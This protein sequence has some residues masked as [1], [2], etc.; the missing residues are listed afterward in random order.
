MP[1]IVETEV[2]TFDE[3]DDE[4]KDR[5]RDWYRDGALDY[6]W[7]EF[8]IEDFCHVAEILG[9]DIATHPVRLASGGTGQ[10][11]CVQF[12]GFHN[13]GDGASFSGFY[14]CAKNSI[15][16]IKLHAP[17]DTELHDIAKRLTV[18]QGRNFW[19][20]YAHITQRGRYCHENTMQV[21]V[22]RYDAEM[23]AD[24]EEIVTETLRDLAR[25]LYRRLE[26]EHE[27]LLSSEVVDDS[28]LANAY[29]FT[30]SG[31]RFG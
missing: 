10:R 22:R 6:D 3:L 4:A 25:W 16:R 14:R 31:E 15:N 27:Y 21:D 24:A 13:Q 29:T 11:H 19:Q 7:W 18:I 28:I 9:L 30:A 5:A 12:S 2:F 26:T 23:T 20:L 1:A 8:V 17:F